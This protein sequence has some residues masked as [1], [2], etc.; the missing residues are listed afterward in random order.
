MSS[1]SGDPRSPDR[2]K[3]IAAVVAVHIALAAVILTGLNVD[4]VRAVVDRLQ[5]FD[6]R[7]V[8]PPRRPPPPPR[9]Q[10]RASAAA[11]A[12]ARRA[13]PAPVVAPRPRIPVP[14]PV[15]A[16]PVAGQ[17]SASTSGAAQA[18]SGTGAGG[19]GNGRGGG[20]NGYAGYTPA[21]L[22]ANIPSS[23]YG[24]LASTGIPSGQVGVS[25][26][27]EPDGSVANCRV[28]RSSGDTSIDGLVCRL[29]VRYVR[30][31]PARDPQ[32]RAI[33]Q[34]ITYFRNWR[35]R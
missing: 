7:E 27:V 34:E 5:T 23:E 17:G 9:R 26:L 25:I 18:G 19:S 1:Y 22:V 30:F 33:A 15:Q 2:A 28:A 31:S 12:P 10:S 35:Q 20:G 8:V 3:A 6:S 13:Q 11:G 14:S 24:R 29:T 32:G 21:R 16:A 4:K